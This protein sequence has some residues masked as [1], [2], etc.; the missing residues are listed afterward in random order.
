MSE[1]S[2]QRPMHWARLLRTVSRVGFA[3]VLCAEL[4][5]CGNGLGQVGGQVT[6]DGVPVKGGKEGARVTVQFQP[7]DGVGANGIGLADENGKYTIGTGS[8]F[9]VRPGEYYVSCT[10]NS[11]DANGPKADPKFA[12]T[13]TSGLKFTVGPGRNEFNIP[14]TSPPKKAK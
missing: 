3:I 13:K 4:T 7:A 6:L 8:Q 14:L 11:L 9:G 2:F 5:G 1:S 10:V 12:S